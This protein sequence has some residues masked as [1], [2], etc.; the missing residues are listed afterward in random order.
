MFSSKLP[1]PGLT[2][3]ITMDIKVVETRV[4]LVEAEQEAVNAAV[5]AANNN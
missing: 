3:E 2:R 5:R 4:A 1:T